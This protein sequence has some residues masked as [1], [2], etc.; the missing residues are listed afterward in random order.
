MAATLDGVVEGT[1][2]VFEAK[3]ML[4]WSFSEE[5]GGREAAPHVDLYPFFGPLRLPKADAFPS[6]VI[7]NEINPCRF[8]STA[9]SRLVRECDRDLP[10]NDLG[11]TDGRHADL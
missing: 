11:S 10:I 8:E 9:D 1:G 6:P 3:F 2:A 5:G 4:A 7:L